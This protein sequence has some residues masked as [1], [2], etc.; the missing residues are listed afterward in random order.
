MFPLAAAG[1]KGLQGC[2]W[3]ACLKEQSCVVLTIAP[4][5]CLPA[6]RPLFIKPPLSK[7]KVTVAFFYRAVL[8]LLLGALIWEPV[9]L[10]KPLWMLLH[11]VFYLWLVL[12]RRRCSDVGVEQNDSLRQVSALLA[13]EESRGPARRAASGASWRPCQQHGECLGGQLVRMPCV[14]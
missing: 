14:A 2:V 9:L 6:G 10:E 11:G 1:R 12:A 5:S 13:S 4:K 8:W 3:K 7:C